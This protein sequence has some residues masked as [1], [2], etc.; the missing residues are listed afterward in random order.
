MA[1]LGKLGNVLGN[2]AGPAIGVGTSALLG[3]GNP[4]A[5]EALKQTLLTMGVGGLGGIAKGEEEERMRK[6]Q[7]QAEENQARANL[8]NAINPRAGAQ[9]R[10]VEMPKAGRMEK[11]ARA[12]VQGYDF[13]K[14]AEMAA[15][16]AKEMKNRLAK[17]ALEEATS[18]GILEAQA[19]F[20]S[21]TEL[22]D[23]P[24]TLT[25]T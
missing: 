23:A 2:L 20:G 24:T 10:P 21:G 12:G 8:I 4:F 7:K 16:A 19:N 15:Q 1:F 3:G 6:A 18:K 22:V 11:F 14:K 13:F 9:A 25:E 5:G 17:Q